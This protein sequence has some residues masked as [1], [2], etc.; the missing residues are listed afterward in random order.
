VFDLGT[1]DVLIS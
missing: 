1:E